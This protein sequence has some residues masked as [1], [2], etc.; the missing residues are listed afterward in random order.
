MTFKCC[1]SPS[2]WPCFHISGAIMNTFAVGNILW[3]QISCTF[4]HI[5]HICC[6]LYGY[7]I[8]V[9]TLGQFWFI[10]TRW[11]LEYYNFSHPSHASEYTED[12]KCPLKIATVVFLTHRSMTDWLPMVLLSVSMFI[13]GAP[14]RARCIITNHIRGRNIS[15]GPSPGNSQSQFAPRSEWGFKRLWNWTI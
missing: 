12:F 10:S 13:T 4:F 6:D 2:S 5:T 9:M 14:C 3:M 7:S 11:K 1:V 15:P 8:Y